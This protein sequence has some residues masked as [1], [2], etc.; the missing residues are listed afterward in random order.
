MKTRNGRAAPHL[1]DNSHWGH[2]D[3]LLPAVRTTCPYCGVGCGL[4]AGRRADG[5]VLVKGDHDHPANYGKLCS[6][7]SALGE[8]VGLEGRLLFPEIGGERA[9]WDAAIDLIAARFSEAISTHGPDSVAF[10]VS[11]Q[12]LTEDYYVANKLMKGFI[13]SANIDTNSRLCMASSVAGHR[14]AFGSDTVPGTYEDIDLADL[15][16]VA[17]SNLAWCHPVTYQRLH[18]AKSARPHM[19]VVLIDPRATLTNHIADHHLAISPDGDLAL[20]SGLLAYLAEN[21]RVDHSYVMEH[22]EGFDDALA[23]ARRL[24]MDD[25][26]AQ[27]GLA[28]SEIEAFYRLFAS[29]EKTVTIYSQGINQSVIGT[30]KVNAIINCHLATG[31]IGKPGAGPFSITGQ[32]NAMGGREVGGLANLLACHMDLENPDHRDIANR[33][34]TAPNLATKPGLKAVDLFRAIDNGRIKALW[35]MATNPVDS[36]PDGEVAE[37]ALKRCPFV[38][39][40]DV[41]SENDTLRHAHVRLPALAWGEKEGTV[42]NSERRI[43]RQRSFLPAPGEAKPDWWHICQVAQRM[44]FERDFDYGGPAAIY[45]EYAAMTA[46]ENDG[47]RDLDLGAHAEI[48]DRAYDELEPFFWPHRLG[49]ED[50]EVRFFA[51]GG[52]FTANGRARFISVS[53]QMPERKDEAY[54]FT[55]NTGRLRDQWHTMT[56]TGKSPRLSAHM[57]EPHCE[58]HPQDAIQLAI[59]NDTLVRIESAQGAVIARALLSDGQRLGD[60]FLSMHWT[61]QF[62]SNGRVNQ[63]VPAVTDAVSGQPASKN[64]AARIA[65][66]NAAHHGFA[67]FA[68]RPDM[69]AADY[70]ATVLAEPGWRS[71]F[72]FAQEIEDLSAHARVMTASANDA[73]LHVHRDP[74]TGAQRMAFFDGERLLSAFLFSSTPVRVARA[75]VSA[76]LSKDYSDPR[77]RERFLTEVFHDDQPDPGRMVCACYGVGEND[78]RSAID[79]G[80]AT[81]SAIG[82]ALGAGSYCGTCLAEIQYIIDARSPAEAGVQDPF[83]N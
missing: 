52:F 77:E 79:A 58:I 74:A 78:I 8:T 67:V 80:S 37:A 41:V 3:Y 50:Q 13:G 83:T 54:P 39:V 51:K 11:G 44:G 53:A 15:V 48:S 14:R 60:L 7:G 16:V 2:G 26:V 32:P 5:S 47:R 22:T 25:I 66:L 69:S 59:A 31:R 24:T 55:L 10:Y 35:I 6:K 29:T 63:L 82:K 34:W 65:P 36:L 1:W 4:L 27:T 18:A 40:S 33:F 62:A 9:S 61:D 46:F 76:H 21:D 42:T 38:V 71:E 12:L 75:H 57:T 72:A 23:A 73:E 81:V 70:W 19:R 56:R 68:E 20:F 64:I 45:R 49:L 43:S 17:G 28:A 30:D